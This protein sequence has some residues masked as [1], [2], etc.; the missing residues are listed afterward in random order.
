MKLLECK[1]R[2]SGESEI[3]TGCLN[4]EQIQYFYQRPMSVATYIQ[5]LRCAVEVQMTAVEFAAKLQ[6]L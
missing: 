6:T 2:P 4:A 3:V 5:L 1:Y